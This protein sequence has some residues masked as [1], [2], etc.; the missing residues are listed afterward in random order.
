MLTGN[1]GE[2]SEVYVFLKL[3]G[4]GKLYAADEK[5]NRIPE[6]FYPIIKILR[7]EF[8]NKREYVLNGDI[9][10]I[11]A[12]TKEEFRVS[13][14]AFLDNSS[15]LLNYL[16]SASGRSFGFEDIE[17]FLKTIH[18]CALK[19]TKADKSDI[20]IVVHDL[21]ADTQPT[22]GFSIKSMLGSKSTLF[23]PGRTTNFIYKIKGHTPLAEDLVD[24]INSISEEPKITHRITKLQEMGYTIFFHDIQ[25]KKLKLNLQFIDSDLPKILAHLLLY[26]Y[27]E[28]VGDS[29]NSLLELINEKNP[30][31]F[32]KEFE[33]PFYEH[34]IKNFLTDVAL[35]MTPSKIWTGKYDAT[36]GIIIVKNDGDI[37]CY[38]I[39]NRNEFQEYLKNNTKL[40][41]ASTSRYEFGDVYLDN[42]E[43]FIKLNLQIRFI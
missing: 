16:K 36:G 29:L 11:N 4:E 17:R 26:K 3:V 22:L 1:K 13:K 38:H 35:G 34:K 28:K 12:A 33:H 8:N 37:V 18:C 19:P 40:E 15:K 24:Q 23:N 5:L 43:L 25:E 21:R 41:Q 39:Y 27:T 42:G 14:R 6:Q 10:I 2:W 32:D 30:L 9:L 7:E 20:H 31:S